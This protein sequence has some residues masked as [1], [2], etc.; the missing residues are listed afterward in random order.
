[1]EW[2]ISPITHRLAEAGFEV[3]RHH[4]PMNGW[5]SIELNAAMLGEAI[6]IQ[7]KKGRKVFVVGHSMGGLVGKHSEV[8]TDID[9]LVT[10]GTPHAGTYMAYL[11]PWSKSAKQMRPGSKFVEKKNFFPAM[12]PMLNIACRFD[13]A[14]LPG[15]NAVHQFADEVMWVNHGH[16]SVIYSGKVAAKVVDFFKAW[17]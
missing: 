10:I 7:K 5:G 16:L 12:A 2:S 4:Q 17:T 14:I 13:L 11:A 1:M 9:G 6:D 8:W 3:R 15:A